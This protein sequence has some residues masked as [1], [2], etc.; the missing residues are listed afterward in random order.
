MVGATVTA[1]ARRP[2]DDHGEGTTLDNPVLYQ[3]EARPED[4]ALDRLAGRVPCSLAQRMADHATVREA[5]EQL[6]EERDAAR[7]GHRVLTD[8][9]NELIEQREAAEAEV[10]RLTEGLREIEE[11]TSALF[12]YAMECEQLLG[13][14]GIELPD[15]SRIHEPSVREPGE[16]GE[17]IR[18]L[19]SA[20]PS[21]GDG[22]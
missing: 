4:D 22:A 11:Y 17:K 13:E 8:A 7:A 20:S 19:L 1:P 6:R 5:L 15:A 21:D 16:L 9:Q 10:R 3:R 18:A 2:E 12:T 14:A